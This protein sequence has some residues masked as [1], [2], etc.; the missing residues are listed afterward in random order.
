LI[1][2]YINVCETNCL[3][4]VVSATELNSSSAMLYKCKLDV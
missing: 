1:T 2:F 3:Q 4:S